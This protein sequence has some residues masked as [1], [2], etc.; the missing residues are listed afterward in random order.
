MRSARRRGRRRSVHDDRA[1]LALDEPPDHR[2]GHLASLPGGTATSS[3]PEVVASVTRRRRHSGTPRRSG[4]APRTRGCAGCRRETR[5]ARRP[6]A[7]RRP[8]IAARPRR[9]PR[10]RAPLAQRQLVQ[11]PEQPEAGHVGHRVGARAPRGGGGRG[12]QRR[13]RRHRAPEGSGPAAPRLRA[14]EIAPTP[15][16]FVST[17]TSPGAP[18]GVRHHLRRDAT[19]PV[20]ARP[21]LGS[22]SSIEWPPTTSAPASA[23]TSARRAGSRAAPRGRA[24]RA[25]R[26]RG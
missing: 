19:T 8:A 17:S 1:G 22:A 14:V 23:T 20:T 2:A 24:A 9:P 21:Y 11:M 18:A 7:P 15:S 6:A 3:P 13:H 4:E 25:G 16:G 10:R 26:R 5:A 12:V